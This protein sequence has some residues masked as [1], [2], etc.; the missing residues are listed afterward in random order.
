MKQNLSSFLV[1][2]SI[3]FLLFISFVGCAPQVDSVTNLQQETAVVLP[4][5]TLSSVTVTPTAP[6]IST[7]APEPTARVAPPTSTPDTT[8]L[9]EP[10][11]L[12]PDSE[13]L[14]DVV[15][16]VTD[17][18]SSSLANM[19]VLT[20]TLPSGYYYAH[21]WGISPEGQQVNRLTS[22]GRGIAWL[23][24]EDSSFPLWLMSTSDLIVNDELIWQIPL[25]SECDVILERDDWEYPAC[26]V[27]KI[28]PDGKWASFLVGDY[29]SRNNT[30]MGLLNLET[31][32]VQ[33]L[34]FGNM[35]F[36]FLPNDKRLVYYSWGE[37]GELRWVDSLTGENTSL[38]CSAGDVFWN[39][40]ETA[41]AVD[42]NRGIGNGGSVWAYDI[43]TE[44]FFEASVLPNTMTSFPLLLPDGSL[45][46]HQL[47]V[48]HGENTTSTFG[49]REVRL[50][51]IST[52]EVRV[53][54][55]DPQSNF[56]ICEDRHPEECVWAGDWIPIR[57][58]PYEAKTLDFEENDGCVSSGNCGE[59]IENLAFNWRTGEIVPWEDVAHLL[60][61]P[62]S[63]AVPVVAP[64]LSATP[65]YENVEMGY[66]LYPGDDERSI[67]CVPETGVA[68]LWVQDAEWFAYLP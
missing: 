61:T 57:H 4:S 32:D 8:C 5:P 62:S 44:S 64:D 31:G 51:N 15:L 48:A 66:A 26:G 12:L 50:A 18:G 41:F 37:S 24:P 23:T 9:F 36:T 34:A 60:P 11:T 58:M 53:V 30:Q 19:G 65:I 35:I 16:F 13:P 63:T 47:S 38:G 55:S 1:F 59:P 29:Y 43:P 10:Q 56:A 52:G 25:P 40:D 45:L 3:V 42:C 67:W 21:L 33:I 46:Y 22:D 68:Q 39:E 28:S 27:F 6:P 14:K 54:L 17:S 7:F 49:P 20:D 2:P